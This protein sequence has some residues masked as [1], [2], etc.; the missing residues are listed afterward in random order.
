[1]GCGSTQIKIDGHIIKQETIKLDIQESHYKSKELV[2]AQQLIELITNLRN[3]IIY[4]Y[5]YLIY[6]TKE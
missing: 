4:E 5:D 2:Q 3:K 6:K 1:M